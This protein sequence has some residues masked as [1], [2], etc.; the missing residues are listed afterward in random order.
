MAKKTSQLYRFEQDLQELEGL[1]AQ[2]E[3]GDISL[4]DALKHFA[5]GVEL[6]RAC[7]KALRHAEQQVQILTTL[8]DQAIPAPA[9]SVDE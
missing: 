2:L 5:R 7:Q 6:S 4:E 9:E 1:V 8:D 3:Q